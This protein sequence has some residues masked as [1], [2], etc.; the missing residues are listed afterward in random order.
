MPDKV[1][2][3]LNAMATLRC[4]VCGRVE[5]KDVSELMGHATM[6][7]MKCS[8]S[9]RHRYSVLL[10]RRRAFRKSVLLEGSLVSSSESYSVV[11]EN[12]SLYGARLKMQEASLL[13]DGQEVQIEFTLDDPVASK[14]FRTARVK[15]FLSPT[16]IGCEF[17][18]NAAD[19]SLDRYLAV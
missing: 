18:S 19:D 17:F 13:E 11:V 6:T 4:P 8:C 15:K 14:I 3:P 16:N 10:E 12:V 1:F 7:E 5:E 9:C 2:V